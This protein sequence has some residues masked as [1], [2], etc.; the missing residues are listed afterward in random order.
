MLEC[1]VTSPDNNKKPEERDRERSPSTG[2]GAD[3]AMDALRRKR[4][5]APRRT[6]FRRRPTRPGTDQAAA[7]ARRARSRATTRQPARIPTSVSSASKN[8]ST[9]ALAK[10][11][12][13]WRRRNFAS[14]RSCATSMLS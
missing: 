1:L 7:T 8:V 2:E 11:R 6:P 9:N 12:S 10:L 4:R 5:E 13:P 14:M 3:S